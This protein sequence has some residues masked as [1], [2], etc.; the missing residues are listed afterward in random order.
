MVGRLFY[1]AGPLN[2]ELAVGV[3][4]DTDGIHNVHLIAQCYLGRAVAPFLS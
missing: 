2:A 1:N 3:V 4:E